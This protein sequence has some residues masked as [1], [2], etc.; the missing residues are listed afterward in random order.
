VMR[1]EDNSDR[2]LAKPMCQWAP[3]NGVGTVCQFANLYRRRVTQVITFIHRIG[4]Q[5]LPQLPELKHRTQKWERVLGTIR[6][7]I[8]S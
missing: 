3:V 4:M 6:C 1:E 7:S 5:L 8:K 2:Q